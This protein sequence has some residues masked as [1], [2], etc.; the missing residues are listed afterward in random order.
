MKNFVFAALWATVV[1]LFPPP[2]ATWH[3]P[4]PGPHLV[5]KDFVAPESP[6]G[7]GHRGVDIGAS[8]SPTLRAPVSGRLRFVGEVVSRG[9]VTIETREGLLVSMEPV[10]TALPSGSA[11]SAGQAIGIV[12]GGHCSTACLHLGVRRN[13][14]YLSPMVFLGYERR[15]V[16]LP[17]WD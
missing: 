10:T 15:A 14:E 17:W 16:L 5:V 4:V 3:W 11:V 1:G 7:P 8:G 9:V 12:E 13:G 2:P 6:W